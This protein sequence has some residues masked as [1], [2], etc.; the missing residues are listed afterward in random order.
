[1]QSLRKSS[2]LLSF[3]IPTHFWYFAARSAPAIGFSGSGCGG[4]GGCIAAEPSTGFWTVPSSFFFLQPVNANSPSATT[5][6]VDSLLI[7]D[8][9]GAQTNARRVRDQPNGRLNRRR[10]GGP[11]ASSSRGSARR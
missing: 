8:L 5:S 2:S 9:L 10:R 1:M 4:G 11:S 6:D 3:T 7:P